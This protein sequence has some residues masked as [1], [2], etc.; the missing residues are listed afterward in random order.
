MEK[1][2]VETPTPQMTLFGVGIDSPVFLDSEEYKNF[3][4]DGIC[5]PVGE[6][7]Y[8]NYDAIDT[9]EYLGIFAGRPDV[10]KKTTKTG[11]VTFHALDTSE[12]IAKVLKG[13]IDDG[14]VLWYPSDIES[15]WDTYKGF[16]ERG[17]VFNYDYYEL[18]DK[19]N[20]K[21]E[22]EALLSTFYL[23]ELQTLL[24]E[25]STSNPSANKVIGFLKRL[26][27]REIK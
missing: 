25:N 5:G 17:I 6:R 16:R 8:L 1:L 10:F 22:R 23:Q 19:E 2:F 7:Y 18:I 20:R 11:E 15:L 13:V 3:P 12:G 14:K 24:N 4:E 21:R 9:I 27:K 26:T